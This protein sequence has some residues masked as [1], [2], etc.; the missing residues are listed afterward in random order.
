MIEIGNDGAE[1]AY[2]NYWQTEHAARGFCYL[3]G[4][5]GAWRLLVPA[6]AASYLDEMR[7]GRSVTIEP[8][9]QNQGCWDLVFE[10]GTS[11]PFFLAVDKRQV[12][13]AIEPGK[14]RLT[15]WT[16]DGKQ[17]DLPCNVRV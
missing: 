12:E 4:N 11:S 1:I 2:T 5:A 15:V 17:L 10:D 7:T 14:Y 9:L 3:S 6:A 8:S 16:E 13:R